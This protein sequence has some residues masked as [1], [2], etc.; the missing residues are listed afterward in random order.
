MMIIGKGG[1]N[2]G[3]RRGVLTTFTSGRYKKGGRKKV[4][5][6]PK[7]PTAWDMTYKPGENFVI[8]KNF[9]YVGK[10]YVLATRI[11]PALD[12]S[13]NKKTASGIFMN[14]GKGLYTNIS[15][16][17]A[18]DILNSAGM[19]PNELREILKKTGL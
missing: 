3:S 18:R 9:K 12:A 1:Y 2:Q 5:P 15:E 11:F 8:E 16:G 7:G 14:C 19:A 17:R 4:L 13:G 10:G 6:A